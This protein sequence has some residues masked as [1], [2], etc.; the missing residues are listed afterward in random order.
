VKV[1]RGKHSF[2]VQAT[3]QAG[4]TDGSP[5]TDDWKVKRRRKR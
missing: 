1:K 2:N 3:D 4:N 5:G